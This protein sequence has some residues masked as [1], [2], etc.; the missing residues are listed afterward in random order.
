[1]NYFYHSF[2]SKTFGDPDVNTVQKAGMPCQPLFI[3][4]IF[5]A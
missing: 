5:T 3:M 1:M 4:I 2:I